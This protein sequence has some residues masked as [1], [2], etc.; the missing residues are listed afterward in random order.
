MNG[1]ILAL[2]AM[3]REPMLFDAI[4]VHNPITDLTNFIFDQNEKDSIVKSIL[5]EQYGDIENETIYKILKHISPYEHPLHLN[6]RYLT[7]LLITYDHDKPVHKIH[8]R[9]FIAKMRKVNR[10]GDYM[11][12]REFMPNENNQI[13]NKMVNYSFLAT[14]LLF[15]VRK[16]HVVYGKSKDI[17]KQLRQMKRKQQQQVSNFY[18][19]LNIIRIAKQ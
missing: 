1:S 14:S 16:E 8:A 19:N 4:S 6:H 11:F 5:R 7:D 12:L 13:Y 17:E 9:K 2:W 10:S 15:R 3:M 18:M